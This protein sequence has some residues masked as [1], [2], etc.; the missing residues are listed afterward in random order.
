VTCDEPRNGPCET[1]TYF[2]FVLALPRYGSPSPTSDRRRRATRRVLL[3]LYEHVHGIGDSTVVWASGAAEVLPVYVC[4][5]AI[6]RLSVPWNVPSADRSLISS[7][8][9]VQSSGRTHPD[10]TAREHLSLRLRNRQRRSMLL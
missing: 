4:A 2:P 1:N 7:V 10:A 5:T 8:P 3:N 9:L 6:M